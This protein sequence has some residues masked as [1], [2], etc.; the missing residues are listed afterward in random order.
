M[1]AGLGVRSHAKRSI[2]SGRRPVVDFANR[3]NSE[4][5]WSERWTAELGLSAAQLAPE[6]PGLSVGCLSKGSPVFHPVM[7]VNG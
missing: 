2:S 6:G 3:Q 4:A 1:N 7:S 5:V